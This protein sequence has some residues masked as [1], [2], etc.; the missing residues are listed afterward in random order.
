FVS[1]LDD[2]NAVATI[3]LTESVIML[4]Y[5]VAIGVSM[6]ATAMVERRVGEKNI[7]AAKIA[8]MQSIYIAVAISLVLG[9]TGFMYAADILKMMGASDAIIAT[10]VNYTRWMFGGNISIILLFLINGIFRGAGNASLAMRS[11]WL[12]NGLNLILDP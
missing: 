1:N 11:L 7:D 3:G 4:V 12:S 10:G 8:A 9:V 2:N 5:S 6:G